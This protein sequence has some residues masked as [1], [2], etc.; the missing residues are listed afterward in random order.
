MHRLHAV[1]HS[2][3][4]CRGVPTCWRAFSTASSLS[5][6]YMWV[7]EWGLPNCT[8]RHSKQHRHETRI[9]CKDIHPLR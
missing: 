2:P 8:C 9:A 4:S 5:Q 3:A 7:R 6:P 1:L